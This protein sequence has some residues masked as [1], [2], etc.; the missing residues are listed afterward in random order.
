MVVSGNE[1]KFLYYIK[2]TLYNAGLVG[3]NSIPEL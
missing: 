1:R 3:N 2:I